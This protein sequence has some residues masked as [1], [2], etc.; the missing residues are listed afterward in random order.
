MTDVR[1][2]NFYPGVGYQLT[3]SWQAGLGDASGVGAIL[4][5]ILNGFVSERY[6]HK[7]VLLVS[8]F[9]LTAFIFMT[10]FAPDVKVLLAGEI[11]C[12]VPWGIFATIGM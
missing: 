12:G 4:G 2:G 6:G 11:L 9:F 10:F 7:R 1:Y 3:P 8:L 5:G